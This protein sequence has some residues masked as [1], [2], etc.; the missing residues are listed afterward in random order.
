MLWRQQ[1]CFWHPL[2]DF[3]VVETMCTLQGQRGR[4]QHP[5]ADFLVTRVF[6]T[7]PGQQGKVLAH[8][9]GFPSGVSY[10]RPLGTT[11]WVPAPSDRFPSCGSYPHPSRIVGQ[12]PASTNRPPSCGSY[13][14]IPGQHGQVLGPADGIPSVWLFLNKIFYFI[15][16]ISKKLWFHCLK[17]ITFVETGN[18]F[19]GRT[20]YTEKGKSCS[21]WESNNAESKIMVNKI[22]GQDEKFL[23]SNNMIN[24]CVS[25]MSHHA[26]EVLSN[27]VKNSSFI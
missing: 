19:I 7:L 1:G 25:N 23:L 24:V 2:M 8:I 17:N 15:F 9:D 26:E 16:V 5:L 11:A 18:T 27:K 14:A 6:C 13:L 22:L 20:Y 4:S 12:V 21:W 3:P 10:P